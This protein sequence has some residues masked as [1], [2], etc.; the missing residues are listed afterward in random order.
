MKQ[1]IDGESYQKNV[2][3]DLVAAFLVTGLS[4]LSKYHLRQNIHDID[5]PHPMQ[6]QLVDLE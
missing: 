5:L 4:Y 3:I 6:S 2:D 1:A